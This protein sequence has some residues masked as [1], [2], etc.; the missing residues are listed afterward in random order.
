M[1]C[2][3]PRTWVI[4]HQLTPKQMRNCH[5]LTTKE[6]HQAS[7]PQPVAERQQGVL[8]TSSSPRTSQSSKIEHS[9]AAPPERASGLPSYRLPVKKNIKNGNAIS[10]SENQKPQHEG[11]LPTGT[12]S[13]TN[14]GSGK[15]R[16]PS[17]LLS[18]RAG[19]GEAGS[20]LPSFLQPVI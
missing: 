14:I 1:D 11:E 15:T 8:T 20:D 10:G 4:G 2:R 5:E 13:T 12:S 16:R 7:E 6:R 9:T 18:E 3:N 19:E 17:P